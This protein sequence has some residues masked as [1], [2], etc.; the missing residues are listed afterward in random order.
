MRKS[1]KLNIVIPIAGEGKR[2][3]EGGFDAP[4]PLIEIQS[5][6]M[7]AHALRSFG[8]IFR[9][10]DYDV[11]LIFVLK[12]E[13]LD[14]FAFA[15]VVRTFVPHDKV[16]FVP[17]D[18]S[19]SG[20]ADTVFRAR[21]FIDC[22]DPLLVFNCDTFVK[23]DMDAFMA[24]SME[25]DGAIQCFPSDSPL[26]S[27]VR[28]EDGRIVEVA[29]KKVI[30]GHATTG[31]Y[32]FTKGSDFIRAFLQLIESMETVNGEYYVAP[33]YAFMIREGKKIVRQDCSSV[34]IFGTPAELHA[35]AH[36]QDV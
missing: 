20:Q 16:S 12:R 34:H 13:L 14:K 6:P 11:H 32:F 17:L 27:Y 8:D 3:R 1:R 22:E 7:V 31:L 5:V 35:F 21:D 2:F 23:F 4:K 15:T 26:Y 28:E 33:C 36:I 25:C 30:S 18:E 10:E 19:T 24:T 29:E 9:N